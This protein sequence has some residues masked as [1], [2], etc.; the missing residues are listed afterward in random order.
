LNTSAPSGGVASFYKILDEFTK[1][2]DS[3]INLP[4]DFKTENST[5]NVD[6]DLGDV[7]SNKF[8]SVEDDRFYLTMS[9]IFTDDTK[10]ETLFNDLTSGPDVQQE[11][12]VT[13]A[14][15]EII[16]T[17]SSRYKTYYAAEKQ[18]FSTLE[19]SEQ[20][21]TIK[22]YILPSINNLVT[23]TTPPTVDVEIKTKK[24]KDLY[25]SQNLNDNK[26]FNG[27]VTFN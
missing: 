9:Q 14:I 8:I 11:E 17:I 24:I 1:L 27:K 7:G 19:T 21:V 22:S 16:D 13:E 20:F 3:K 5:L 18:L 2:M 25:A 26:T 12:G 15:R 10:K 6:E 23:Y 4:Q